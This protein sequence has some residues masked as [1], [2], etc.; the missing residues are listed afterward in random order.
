MRRAECT[1]Q[2]A[3][4]SNTISLT[5]ARSRRIGH[6]VA[7]LVATTSLSLSFSGWA[8]P[9]A[10]ASRGVVRRDIV[11]LNDLI[12]KID[13][14]SVSI[15]ISKSERKE[16][17]KIGADFQRSY[18]LQEL[19]K[20][21]LLEYKQSG[22]L[23]LSGT[24]TVLGQASLIMNGPLRCYHVKHLPTRVEDLK[25]SP[26]K[27]QSLLEYGGLLS[28]ET[29]TFMQGKFVKEEMVD[30]QNTSV[31]DLTYRG[32]SGGSYFRVWFD[33]KTHLTLKREWYNPEGKLKATFYYQEA[34]EITPGVWLPKQVEIKN[35]DGITAAITTIDLDS[36]R[37][38]KGL[39][40]DLFAISAK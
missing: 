32:T 13:D 11:R 9:R 6:C 15:H 18:Q 4:I 3:F 19:L 12:T 29:L 25:E 5:R 28:A 40:D 27:R 22:K 24:N 20:D 34:Q 30:G 38:N 37:V 17:E 10:W 31:F 35:A 21:I 26:G 1:T 2:F 16:L 36:A 7:L 14:L 33:L 8:T 39:S 23:R